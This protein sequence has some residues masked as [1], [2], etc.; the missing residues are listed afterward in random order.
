MQLIDNAEKEIEKSYHFFFQSNEDVMKALLEY[1][2]IDTLYE[3]IL[4]GEIPD[5]KTQAAI[6][7]VVSLMN[8]GEKF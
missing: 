6:L 2:H 5:G 1:R 7:K 4:Q 8:K 3:K